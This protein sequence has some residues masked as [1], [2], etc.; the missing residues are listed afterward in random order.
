MNS[1]ENQLNDPK[2]PPKADLMDQVLRQ[3]PLDR[4]GTA[5]I[6][7]GVSGGAD[8]V[9]L[10]AL[11]RRTLKNHSLPTRLVVAHVNHGLRGADSDADQEFVAQLSTRWDLEFRCFCPE[12]PAVQRAPSEEALRDVR[13]AFFREVAQEIGARYVAT[14]HH[15]D[16][17]VETV[18]FRMFR[19]TSVSGLAGIPK[20]RLLSPDIT[21]VRPLLGIRRNELREFLAGIGQDFREDISND[22]GQYT[23]NRIRHQVLPQLE[24]EFGVEVSDRLLSLSRQAAEVRDLLSTLARDAFS[25]IVIYQRP[26]EIGVDVT[27][28]CRLAPVIQRQFVVELWDQQGWPRGDLNESDILDIVACLESAT[29]TSLR[30][31][32]PGRITIDGSE[33]QKAIQRRR[34]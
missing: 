11:L 4:W 15:S 32:F 10:L 9:A 19:G 27:A 6:V 14:A 29:P 7:V 26:D 21:L 18:L 22:S 13:Y 23:R 17:Q 12:K 20:F 25:E 3:W 5:P 34:L 31:Q 8:S 33:N 24:Q 1:P 16:D 28:F 2:L 30:H